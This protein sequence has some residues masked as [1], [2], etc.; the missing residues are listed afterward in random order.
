V[1][2]HRRICVVT[3]S[4]A[5]YGLLRR[6]VAMLHADP[7][8]DLDLAVTGMHLSEEYGLTVEAI[9]KDGVPISERIDIELS[10][11][12]PT[13][14]ARS[15]GLGISGFTR[16]FS[17]TEP[18]VVVVLGDRF[19]ILAASI[20][21]L[22]C[23][24]PLAHIAGG[25]VTEGAFDE[26]IRHSITKMAHVHFVTHELAARRVRQ[27]GEDPEL[28]F[29]VGS[30]GIDEILRLEPL[31]RAALESDLGCRFRARNLLLTFHPVTR[32]AGAEKQ[33]GALLEALDQLGDDVGLFFTR[34]NADPGNR[35]YARMLDEWIAQHDNARAFHSL[36]QRRYLS[37]MAEV[38]AVVGNSSSGLYEAPSFRIPTVNVGSRQMGRLAAESVIHCRATAK[39][40]LAAIEEA[41]EMDCSATV[42]PYGD[43][44]GAERIVAILKGLPDLRALLKK[45]FHLVE[46]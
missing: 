34:P 41:F 12:S 3:G 30:P 44:H 9:E 26:S 17:R 45:R 8:I 37:L 22:L 15:V 10:N 39:E 18:D 20:A 16:F 31:G 32:E 1:A 35:L 29:E 43:G 46:V 25:D 21:A 36:G 23:A 27:L 42:N 28:V 4:P 6:L 38:D 19:E 14:V 33:L 11:D 24:V 40:I 13:G 5:D 7:E 2:S